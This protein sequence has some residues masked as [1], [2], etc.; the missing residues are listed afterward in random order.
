MYNL[1]G[2]T[3]NSPGFKPSTSKFRAT[4]ESNERSGPAYCDLNMSGQNMPSPIRIEVNETITC[5]T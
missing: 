2:Q 3:S 5:T 1:D 4:T